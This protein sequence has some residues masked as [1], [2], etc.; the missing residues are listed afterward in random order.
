[1]A[2]GLFHNGVPV[3]VGEEPQAEPVPLAG[4]SEPV[5]GDAGLTGVEGLAHPSVELVVGDEAGVGV[6]HGLQGR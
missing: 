2:P 5:H 1:M 6:G 3:D 4:V